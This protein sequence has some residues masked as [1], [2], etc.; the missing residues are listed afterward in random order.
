MSQPVAVLAT[1]KQFKCI[2]G[3]QRAKI[4]PVV[5]ADTE[6][7]KEVLRQCP[8]DTSHNNLVPHGAEVLL[9][10]GIVGFPVVENET[11]DAAGL[12]AF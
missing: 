8:L 9:F 7:P 4:W 2:S 12:H 1:P 10:P 5:V 3:L 6:S 11:P